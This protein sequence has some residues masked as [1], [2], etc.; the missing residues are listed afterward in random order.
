MNGANHRLDCFTTYPFSIFGQGWEKVVQKP[1]SPAWKGD[2]V[3][4]NDVWI[5]YDSTIM[6]G[7]KIGN[8]AVIAARAVVVKDVE[9]YTIVGGN[10]AK[11]IRKRFSDETIEL[12]QKI[13]WWDW[14]IQKI[15]AH[16]EI[17]SSNNEEQLR[18]IIDG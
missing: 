9:P 5:G 11:P 14:P 18:G 7:V 13:K 6:P 8:G 17:L 3:I 16:L 10:P 1:G 4:Q 12:L 2:T 15:T